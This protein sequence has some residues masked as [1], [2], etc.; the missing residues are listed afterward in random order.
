M[1]NTI[2]YTFVLLL[3]TTWG[4]A[5]KNEKTQPPEGGQPKDFTLPKKEVVRLDNGLTLVMVPYG[6]IPKATIQVSI[7]TGN[8]DEKENQVW[9]SDLLA[10]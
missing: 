9:L 8:I 1:K 3:L 4:F 10:D 2:I 6:S 5:Q 7:K